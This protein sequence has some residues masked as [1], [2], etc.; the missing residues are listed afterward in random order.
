MDRRRDICSQE[1]LGVAET[2]FILNILDS[3][4]RFPLTQRDTKM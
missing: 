2:L 4:L 3:Q 1:S